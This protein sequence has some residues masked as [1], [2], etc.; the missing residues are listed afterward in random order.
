MSTENAGPI[1]LPYIKARYPIVYCLTSEEAR[2]EVE[3]LACAKACNMQLRTW[4]CTE[5]FRNPAKKDWTDQTE[6]PIDALQKIN[7]EPD[8][9]GTIYIFKDLHPFF[10]VAP[11][12]VRL[13]RDIA[14]DFK[15]QKKTLV[16][17]S[18]VNA[19]P[20]ELQREVALID[21]EL[22]A[23]EMI[24]KIVKGLLR[25]EKNAESLKKAEIKIDDG[26]LDQIIEA[27]MGLTTPEAENA[28][29][30]AVIELK[31]T[32][33]PKRVRPSTLVM[34]EKAIAIRKTGVLEY[35]E[36]QEKI[37]DVGGLENLKEWLNIR[38][39]SF[40]KEARDFGLPNPRGLLFVGL[41]GCGKS[42]MAKAAANAFGVPLI[43]FDVGRVFGGLVGQSEQNMRTAIQTAEAVGSSVLWI[44]EIEKAFAGLGSSGATDSGVSARVFG[45]FITWMQE[46][47]APVFIVAT[48]NRLS[49]LPP[50]L[51]RK[52]RFDE[53]F[54]VDLPNAKERE[55]ILKIHITKRGRN[56]AKFD[57]KECVAKS[58][59]FSGAELEEAVISGLYTAFYRKTDLQ[60]LY[61]QS[62]ILRTTPLSV[63]NKTDLEGMALWAKNNA[64]CASKPEEETVA[65][66]PVRE[67]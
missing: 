37:D 26:E 38:K 53:I 51:L 15:Q 21:F 63:S 30:K 43:R 54:F 1:M 50:E 35:Y 64:Q 18:P 24:G 42:L 2:A 48:A 13:L 46:K 55:Q 39:L 17:I 20:V 60:D 40:S 32:E 47:K 65:S 14:R 11:K 62:A 41:P 44:D 10:A 16:L 27:C 12:V 22:P 8:G 29:S 19:L 33:K 67:L 31:D 4:S 9:G 36:A 5:G 58:E 3:V 34:K 56:P 57:L 6:D 25:S 61:V 7:T 45:N 49:G 23:R 59:G 66:V 28:V 52:G